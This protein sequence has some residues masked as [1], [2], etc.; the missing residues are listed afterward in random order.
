[1][2]NYINFVGILLIL[3]MLGAFNMLFTKIDLGLQH[4]KCMHNSECFRE[5]VNKKREG[6]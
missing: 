4:L 5:Y 1:M 6:S 2:I 3:I